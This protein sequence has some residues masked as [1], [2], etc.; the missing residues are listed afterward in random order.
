MMKSCSTTK[1]VFLEWRMYL[2]ITFEA[3]MRCSLSRYAEGS[4]IYQ[5][6]RGQIRGD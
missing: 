2:L 1:A 4:S 5:E 6:R 3:A